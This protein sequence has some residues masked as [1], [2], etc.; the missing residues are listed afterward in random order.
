MFE[1]DWF[2]VNNPD[3]RAIEREW[4][5]RYNAAGDGDSDSDGD[6][7]SD[8]DEI[9]FQFDDTKITNTNDLEFLQHALK[10]LKYES[11]LGE[12]GNDEEETANLKLGGCFPPPPPDRFA[13]CWTRDICLCY[14]DGGL[15]NAYG[16]FHWCGPC[17]C[18]VDANE[19]C[20]GGR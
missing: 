1:P 11:A 14:E 3:L 6:G 17:Q 15:K 9:Q 5:V 19:G 2:D 4:S 16:W 10:L 7:D 8:G 18:Y 13:G 20:C 12:K